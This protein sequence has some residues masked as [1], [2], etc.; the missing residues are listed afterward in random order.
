MP[1][2]PRQPTDSGAHL[3]PSPVAQPREVCDSRLVTDLADLV[4]LRSLVDRYAIAIDRRDKAALAALFVRDGGIDVHLAGRPEPVARM[5]RGAGLGGLV[6]AL[7]IYRDTMHIV[8]NFVPTID[9][10]TATAV[11]YCVAHHWYVEGDESFDERLFVVYDDHFVRTPGG[12]R[13]TV[14]EIHRRWA[15]SQPAGQKPLQVDLELAGKRR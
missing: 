8:A 4:E 10:D 12:W 7:S 13:F 15:E 14:R 5:R 2:T 11:T 9:G 3:P 6:D 1:G